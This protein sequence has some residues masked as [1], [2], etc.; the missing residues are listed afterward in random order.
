[1]RDAYS[2]HLE[3]IQKSSGWQT[4][5][6][7]ETDIIDSS[8]K[9]NDGKSIETESWSSTTKEDKYRVVYVH[10]LWVHLRMEFISF[11][12]FNVIFRALS[13]FS[14]LRWS[15]CRFEWARCWRAV[16]KVKKWD[17]L[18]FFSFSDKSTDSQ[19]QIMEINDDLMLGVVCVRC[20]RRMIV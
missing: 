9:R 8:V 5:K 3:P 15:F 10:R 2:L 18:K 17:M 4:T 20:W 11:A 16:P 6:E 13:Y 19:I 14:S 7:T 1:M 12:E